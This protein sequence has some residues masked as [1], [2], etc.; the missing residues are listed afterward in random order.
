MFLD[1]ARARSTRTAATY[2]RELERLTAYVRKPLPQVTADDL[3]GY[4]AA[5][6]AAGAR[7]PSSQAQI[8][9]ILRRFFRYACQLGYLRLNPAELLTAPRV[10]AGTE[11]RWC[12]APEV[13]A[14]L[15]AADTV[16]STA[17][18]LCRFLA[19]TGL[20][21][22]EAAGVQWSDFLSDPLGNIGLTVVG[23]G[24]K[25]R[26]IRIRPDLWAHIQAFR[27][28]R[29]LPTGLG[30]DAAPLFANRWQRPCSARYLR[31]LVAASVARAGIAKKASPHWFRHSFA[32]LALAAGAD[33][34]KLQRDLGHSSVAT[35]QTYLHV[36]QGLG[37]GTA[38]LV[39]LRVASHPVADEPKS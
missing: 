9:A 26:T 10:P 14:I 32:T 15:A 28:H 13:Q 7:A 18:L 11:L 34:L 17:G 12:T 4:V 19:L 6:A 39:P 22:S 20:R 25:R 21:I 2:A 30:T 35:T 31:R 38:D 8:V 16:N 29:G 27:R 36:A 33:L 37:Q 24:R 3:Q 23:K 5:R 1:R